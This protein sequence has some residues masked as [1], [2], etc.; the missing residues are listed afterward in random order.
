VATVQPQDQMMN[1]A[2]IYAEIQGNNHRIEELGT[3]EG[4]GRPRRTWPQASA[5]SLSQCFGS[6]WTGKVQP[7]QKQ[8]RYRIV[9]PYLGALAVQKHCGGPALPPRR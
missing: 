9:S 3:R 1:C 2:A 4:A 5:V 8:E 7:E 6:E